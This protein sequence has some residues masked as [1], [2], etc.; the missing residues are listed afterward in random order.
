MSDRKFGPSEMDG[1]VEKLLLKK[2][3]DPKTLQDL[4][5]LQIAMHHDSKGR[6]LK[7]LTMI[8]N[9][10]ENDVNMSKVDFDNMIAGFR[11]RHDD[12]DKRMV[13]IE[14]ELD[15]K[16]ELRTQEINGLTNK[17]TEAVEQ[18]E[19]DVHNIQCVRQRDLEKHEEFHNKFAEELH[20]KE[21]G[22]EEDWTEKRGRYTKEQIVTAVIIMLA[23]VAANAGITYFIVHTLEQ[24]FHN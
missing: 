24:A 14:K 13:N 9:H 21:D 5:E 4:F 20:R 19:E 15:R 3:G 10:L 17:F 6:D 2:N 11:K 7:L 8:E 12:R 23:T 18:I 16:W 22:D 1:A